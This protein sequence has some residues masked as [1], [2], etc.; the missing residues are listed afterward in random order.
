MAL[1]SPQ[2]TGGGGRKSVAHILFEKGKITREQ[3]ADV[4]RRM[5]STPGLSADG[6]LLEMGVSDVDITEAQADIAN[7]PFVNL[8]KSPPSDDAKG[9][10]PDDLQ[11]RLKV[12]PLQIDGN[13]LVVAMDNPKDFHTLDDLK[14]RTKMDIRGVMAAPSQLEAFR[15][16]KLGT[17]GLNGNGSNGHANGNGAP[18]PEDS[19]RVANGEEFKYDEDVASMLN[20]IAP[21]EKVEDPNAKKKKNV[22]KVE[23]S[24]EDAAKAGTELNP[25]SVSSDKTISEEAPIIRI[26]NTVLLYALKDGASDIHIEPQQKGVRIRYRID[27]VLHEQMKI[28]QYVLNP[29]ISRIKIMSEM[30]IAERRIPQDGRIKLTMQGKEFDMRVNTCPTVWGEKIVMRILDKSSVMLGLDKIGLYPDHQDELLDIATQPNGMLYVCGPTGSGKTTTLYS[31]LNVVSTIEKNV[32][33]VED[34]VEYQLPGLTQVQVNR[35]A[36]LTFATAL[37][38]FLRQDPDVIMVGEIRDLETAE[39]AVQASLTGHFVLSTI[40]TN[41]APSTATRLGDMGVEP[42]LISASLTGALAQRL[43]RRI[44]SNCKEEYVPPRETLM[45]FGFDPLKNPDQKFWHGRGCDVC[46]QTGYKGRTG[47]YELMR[48]NEEMQELIVRRS[49]VTELREA[50]RANG[51][52]T[53]QEDGFMKCRDG[54]TTVEEVMRV[55]FTG[56][57]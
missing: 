15:N 1:S 33:T 48:V 18:K 51:M 35:K 53:L 29:L 12:T 7:V 8:L 49:P 39:I 56:G 10:V 34:P 11:S 52:R 16:G 3:G 55:V 32:S 54:H 22:P 25:E 26:V 38:A 27:G 19:E 40:H 4:M 20:E 43:A 2:P 23:I 24:E 13:T 36:G 41:D 31:L 21:I 30:N 6:I 46:K 57:H 42:F 9:L 37:R 45:R 5:Q 50:A 14:V 44:C 17:V 47:L 28:P